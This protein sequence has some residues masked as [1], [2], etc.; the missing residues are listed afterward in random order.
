MNAI[1]QIIFTAGQKLHEQLYGAVITIHGNDIPCTSSRVINDWILMNGR[2]P[3]SFV[4][5]ISFRKDQIPEDKIAATIKGLK[6]TLKLTPESAPMALML[7]EGG[8]KPD[9]LT[10]DFHAVDANYTA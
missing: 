2:S 8:L 4:E 9:G 1:N 7:Y 3:K 5:S 6:F 10:Y